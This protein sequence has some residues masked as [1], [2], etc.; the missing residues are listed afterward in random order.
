MKEEVGEDKTVDEKLLIKSVEL[1]P[2]APPA[3]QKLRVKKYRSSSQGSSHSYNPVNGDAAELKIIENEEFFDPPR[4]ALAVGQYMGEEGFGCDILSFKSVEDR[5]NFKHNKCRNLDLVERFIEVK[6]RSS[7]SA[8]I[9][10]RGNEKEA[11][12]RYNNKYY[13][14]RLFKSGSGEYSLSV[15][16]NPL[17]DVDA[18]EHSLYVH[19]DRAKRREE[20]EVTTVAVSNDVTTAT[21]K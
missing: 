14:Y 16:Q 13:I 3:K 20:F 6:G 10:L 15:L 9:E 7:K 19:M 12:S 21:N 1:S 2:K 8:S 5:E 18:I 4:Y 11:A 17:S